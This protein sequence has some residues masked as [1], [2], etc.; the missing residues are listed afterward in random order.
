[1]TRVPII[2][3]Q[4]RRAYPPRQ[5]AVTERFWRALAEGRFVTTA[6]RDC[7]RLTF[8]PK[9][10]C[11]HCWS[12]QVE[13]VP[14]PARG[15]LYSRTTVHAAP[16]VFAGEVP[17]QLCVADLD[18][19]VRIATRLVEASADQ[20]LDAPVEVVALHYDDGP[21]FAVRPLAG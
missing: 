5:S 7:R 15:R 17:Y 21:L 20:A 12:R 1:M 14:A 3:M 10:F 19:G 6:C 16:S 9:D 8:P 11:P 13:W 4:G 18:G 2:A